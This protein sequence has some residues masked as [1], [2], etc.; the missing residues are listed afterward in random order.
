MLVNFEGMQTEL[1]ESLEKVRSLEQKAYDNSLRNY[2]M[3]RLDSDEIEE[4]AEE[5]LDLFS[6]LLTFTN[7]IAPKED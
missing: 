7:L 5:F 3:T 1:K 2:D 4:L 6:L